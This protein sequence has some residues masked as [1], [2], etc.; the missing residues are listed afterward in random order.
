MNLTQDGEK[1]TG[2]VRIQPDQL[3][4]SYAVTDVQGTFDGVTFVF[5]QTRLQENVSKP[6]I[7]WLL[8]KGKLTLNNT[9][10]PPTLVG[11]WEATDN[12]AINGELILR[13]Q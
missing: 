4:G 12:P 6:A 7:N 9:V 5:Q 2:T 8:M 11:P 1:I 3:K 10:I 13:K